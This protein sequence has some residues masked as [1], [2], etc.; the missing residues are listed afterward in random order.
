MINQFPYHFYHQTRSPEQLM[1]NQLPYRLEVTKFDFGQK[2]WPTKNFKYFFII[3]IIGEQL[4][5]GGLFYF[6]G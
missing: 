1:N 2:L 6:L 4:K 5:L 3:V